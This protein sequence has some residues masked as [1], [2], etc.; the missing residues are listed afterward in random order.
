M[1][2]TTESIT[3]IFNGLTVCLASVYR[4]W[5]ISKID[6]CSFIHCRASEWVRNSFYFLILLQNEINFQEFIVST[7]VLRNETAW[8]VNNGL[9]L[10]GAFIRIGERGARGQSSTSAIDRNNVQFF[11]LV[12]QNA[13]GCW[14]TNTP[15]FSNS[16]D[17]VHQDNSTLI[18]P[19][20]LKIDQ[21]V[22]QVCQFIVSLSSKTTHFCRLQ[23]VWVL[24]N[25]LP[26]YLYSQLNLND[27]NF[28]IQ[29]ANVREIV[30][31]TTCDSSSLRFSSILDE[32]S[33]VTAN[34]IIWNSFFL[35]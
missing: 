13:I 9:G 12:Q 15:Y 16:L 30:V 34:W 10:S 5:M 2:V 3:S 14:N 32:F 18:F 17:V 20:D 1:H 25:R 4:R 7:S 31:G 28:R 27:V 33:A 19:N 26:V 6:F 35:L 22:D 29:R 23:N 11:N 24:S 8:T 21:E